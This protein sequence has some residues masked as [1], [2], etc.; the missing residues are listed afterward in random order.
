[1]GRDRATGTTE[2]SESDAVEAQTLSVPFRGVAEGAKESSADVNIALSY[3]DLEQRPNGR[4]KRCAEE[5]TGQNRVCY[6]AADR[7]E[8]NF[9]SATLSTTSS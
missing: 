1:M 5:S 2:S 9:A 3:P 7:V 4:A 6:V 8:W